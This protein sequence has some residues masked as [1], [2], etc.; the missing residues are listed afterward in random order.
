VRVLATFPELFEPAAADV[1][2]PEVAVQP[3]SRIAAEPLLPAA[4]PPFPRQSLG[5]NPLRISSRKRFPTGSIIALTLISAAIWTLVAVRERAES[6][7]SLPE[8][9][10]ASEPSASADA[11]VTR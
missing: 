10:L 11:E 1:V 7:R 3:A 4:E 5:P 2:G 9:R 6:D 8:T